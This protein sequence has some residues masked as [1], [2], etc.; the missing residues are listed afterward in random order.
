MLVIGFSLAIVMGLVLGLL[1]GG[2]SILTVPILVY[3]FDV[4]ATL[5]TGYSLFIVGVT[6]LIGALRY[7]RDHLLDMNVAILFSIPSVV[8]VLVSRLWILPLV[9]PKM[10][11]MNIECSKDQLILFVFSI[12]IIVIALFMFK[13]K[14]P[15]SQKER[16]EAN[17]SV[18]LVSIG[19]EGFLV[20][21][22]TGFVGAGGGFMIVP[23]LTLLAKIPLKKAIATSL[24]I[25]SAKSII[26]FLGDL[27]GGAVF[28]WRLLFSLLIATLSGILIGTKL[29][30]KLSA[31]N[32]R[33]GFA[34]FILIMGVFILAK[35][36]SMS[37]S[38]NSQKNKLSC[39]FY[40][41]TVYALPFAHQ[42]K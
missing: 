17:G 8:G 32:L 23:A 31:K 5:A 27:A 13:S 21:G 10:N 25:I 36:F 4:S 2:G 11:L 26:G 18:S 29:G 1:G 30:H 19:I 39:I 38:T 35:E 9:P 14:D 37:K 41:D 22:V 24:L 15:D 42:K 7:R 16:V 28:N 12:L 33:K 20:G 40:K 6:S 34:Y 3:F